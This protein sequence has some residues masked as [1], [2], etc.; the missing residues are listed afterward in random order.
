MHP[1]TPEL[2]ER[3]G[4]SLKRLSLGR[5]IPALLRG[6]LLPWAAYPH[7]RPAP[8]TAASSGSSASPQR[9]HPWDPGARSASAAN[10]PRDTAPKRGMSKLGSGPSARQLL[11]PAAA[12]ATP[13]R[14]HHVQPTS[15]PRALAFRATGAPL[16]PQAAPGPS[17]PNRHLRSHNRLLT[18]L[19]AGP[20]TRPLAAA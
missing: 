20:A 14:S 18:H 10:C 4:P 2:Q 7:A 16:T 19:H 17:T 8:L 5:P 1:P 13:A 6:T 3:P 9:R 11:G 15:K 12:Q